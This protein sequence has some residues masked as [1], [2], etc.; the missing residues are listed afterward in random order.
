MSKKDRT[1]DVPTGVAYL[2]LIT[3][4]I[5]FKLITTGPGMHRTKSSILHWI[6]IYTDKATP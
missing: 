6:N 4:L 1:W 5:S 2:T 3:T